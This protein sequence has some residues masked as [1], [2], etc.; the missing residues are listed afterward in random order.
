MCFMY[1]R[2]GDFRSWL[3]QYALLWSIIVVVALKNFLC[4]DPEQFLSPTTRHYLFLAATHAT[5]TSLISSFWRQLYDTFIITISLHFPLCYS[6]SIPTQLLRILWPV[7][8]WTLQTSEPTNTSILSCL[9]TLST[10][11]CAKQ[12]MLTWTTLKALFAHTG[13]G[14]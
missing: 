9:S 1:V 10:T 14:T 12:D 13:R 7:L 11:F 6:D 8:P 3:A 2:V 4:F 5:V